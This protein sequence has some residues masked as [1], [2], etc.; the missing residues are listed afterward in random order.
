M[1]LSTATFP[2]R[3][4]LKSTQSIRPGKRV[5]DPYLTTEI[6]GKSPERFYEEANLTYAVELM[7]KDKKSATKI[8]VL[9]ENYH[10]ERLERSLRDGEIGSRLAR[11]RVRNHFYKTTQKEEQDL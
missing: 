4:E 1:N 5:N 3:S 7:K 6:I 11:N 9:L 8:K 10:N 2:V